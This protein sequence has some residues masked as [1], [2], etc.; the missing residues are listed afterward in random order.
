MS[1]IILTQYSQFEANTTYPCSES[2]EINGIEY[3][4]ELVPSEHHSLYSYFRVDEETRDKVR[5]WMQRAYLPSNRLYTA[6]SSYGLKHDMHA[7]IQ[8]YM[9]SGQYEHAMIDAG[10]RPGDGPKKDFL[11]FYISKN[12]PSFKSSRKR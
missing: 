8:I 12:S 3:S 6:Y 10:F 2:I 7:H 4:K 5:Y 9:T 1:P 11:Y